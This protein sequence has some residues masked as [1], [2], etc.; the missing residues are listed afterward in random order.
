MR[1]MPAAARARTIFIMVFLPRRGTWTDH[2][3]SRRM[4]ISAGFKRVG[5]RPPSRRCRR[6]A[7]GFATGCLGAVADD[8]GEGDAADRATRRP[9]PRGYYSTAGAAE[10][11]TPS[12]RRTMAIGQNPV[13]PLWAN[14]KPTKPVNQSQFWL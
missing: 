14:M 12:A 1:T 3:T 13:I 9:R 7:L 11:F 8:S 4:T 6:G 5:K 2:G 10:S